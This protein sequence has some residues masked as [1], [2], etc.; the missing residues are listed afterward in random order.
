ME[1][2]QIIKILFDLA[3]KGGFDRSIAEMACEEFPRINMIRIKAQQ[4]AQREYKDFY[5]FDVPDNDTGSRKGKPTS[6]DYVYD[7]MKYGKNK[8]AMPQA[9]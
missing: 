1:R 4:A 2:D 5:Q 6:I 7:R 8:I 9:G 3:E